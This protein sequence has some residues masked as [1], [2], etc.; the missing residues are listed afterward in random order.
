MPTYTY[1]CADCGHQFDQFQKFTDDPLTDCPS[2]AGKVRRVIQPVGVVFKGSGWYITDS[3]GSSS[4]SAADKAEKPA[5]AD[6]SAIKSDAGESGTTKS[7]ESTKPAE[8]AKS[9]EK[10]ETKVAASA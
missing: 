4:A 8:P 7:T 5:T 6:A 2:C 9:P 1:R 10:K 3:R